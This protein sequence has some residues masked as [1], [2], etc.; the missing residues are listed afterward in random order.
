MEE[1]IT[2]LNVKTTQ[3]TKTPKMLHYYKKPEFHAVLRDV[4]RKFLCIFSKK[5]FT[6]K[7]PVF[8]DF[9]KDIKTFEIQSTALFRPRIVAPFE[10]LVIKEKSIS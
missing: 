6:K 10:R 8:P 9:P 2:K 4:P 1:G 7:I 5:F 3:R